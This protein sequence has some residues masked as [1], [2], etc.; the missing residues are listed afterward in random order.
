M[1]FSN[2]CDKENYPPLHFNITNV[3]VA[4]SQKHLGLVLDSKLNFNEHIERKITKCNKIT[5]LMKKLSQFLS[6]KSLLTIYESFIRPNLDYA[7][8][9]YDKSLNGS[10]KKKIESVRYNTALIITGAIKGTFRVKI[11]QELGLDSLADRRWSTKLIFFHKIVL[12]LQPS[13]LQN[14]LTP[15]VN[16]RPYLTRY[17]TQKLMK[18]FKGRT[19]AFKSSLFPYCAKEWGNLSEELR[20]I[21]SIKTFKLSILD[22]VRSR[23][24][25]VFAFH[26]INGLKLLTRLR[27][28]FTYL[29]EHK[30]RHN[31]NDTINPMCS[32]GK[33]SERTLHYLLRYDI[34]SIYRLE[35][36]NDICAFNHSLKNISEENLLKIL[37]YGAE[38][39]FFKINSGVLKCRIK[40]SGP[41]FLS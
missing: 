17:A 1:C 19:K 33:E 35:L 11:Y 2:K 34:Y 40:F 28:N 29:N 7:D 8:I 4:D 3:Q 14:Y 38:E 41:L 16:E 30:F 32:C 23:E 26:D 5:G 21:D 10:F 18:T 25:A 31:F 20:N 15:Y 36:L 9:T 27:S 22:F 12:G 39:F 13:Y 24:N 6:R 37:L